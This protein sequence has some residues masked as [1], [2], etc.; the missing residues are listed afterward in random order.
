MFLIAISTA[1]NITVLNIF[2]RGEDGRREVPGWL[3]TLVLKYMAKVMCMDCKGEYLLQRRTD[4]KLDQARLA[5]LRK[6]RWFNARS[7]INPGFAGFA[8]GRWE[9]P[10]KQSVL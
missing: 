5:M 1:M 8:V 6:Q 7:A 4:P 9:K 10:R 3:R 2:H